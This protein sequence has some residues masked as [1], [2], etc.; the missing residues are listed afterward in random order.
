MPV[1]LSSTSSV[2]LTTCTSTVFFP[3]ATVGGMAVG[4]IAVEVLEG[5]TGTW[6]AAAVAVQGIEVGVMEGIA[7]TWDTVVVAVAGIEEVGVTKGTIFV[8]VAS[9][10]VV[11]VEGIVVG[12]GEDMG[13]KS[14]APA[15]SWLAVLVLPLISL[16]G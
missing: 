14:N 13:L 8:G 12:A 6:D 10:V 2:P 15:S 11:A 1:E 5:I 9:E 4:K 16:F 7:G 3:A